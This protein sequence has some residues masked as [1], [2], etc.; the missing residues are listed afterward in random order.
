M[1]LQKAK[2]EFEAG[3]FKACVDILEK[4]ILSSPN[5]VEALYHLAISYRRL[6]DHIKSLAIFDRC[7]NLQPEDM[8]FV[9]ERGVCKFHLK[10]KHG[11]LEDM[12]LCV[13][14][15]PENPYRYSCRAYIRSNM[16]DLDGAIADYQKAADLDPEDAIALNNL[17][18]LEEKAGKIE[19]S[20]RTFKKSDD[21]IGRD[22]EKNRDQY[23]QE[24]IKNN[25]APTVHID[26]PENETEKEKL[27]VKT[28]FSTMKYALGTKEGRNEFFN[29]L[30]GKQPED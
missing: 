5:D 10:D 20:K 2:A 15:D 25:P 8:D 14:K 21:L 28:F 30:K 7:V 9:S 23:I 12:D 17:G 16:N 11:A 13:E 29:F 19:A 24:Y 6:D 18:M 27:T 3:N 26:I 4:H 1:A 22:P